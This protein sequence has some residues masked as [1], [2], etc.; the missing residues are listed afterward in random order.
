MLGQVPPAPANLYDSGRVSGN[1]NT[2][3]LDR[4]M[5]ARLRTVDIDISAVS[6]LRLLIMDVGSYSPERVRPAWVGAVLIGANGEMPLS[7]LRPKSGEALQTAVRLSG[8]VYPDALAPGLSELV[9]DIGGK[10]YTRL[11]AKIGLADECLQN[12]ISPAVRFFVFKDKPDLERLVQVEPGVPAPSPLRNPVT[13]DSVISTLF[14]AML[15]RPPSLQ[16]QRLASQAL[17]SRLTSE[18]LA[19]LLW[20]VAMQPEFQLIY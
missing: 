5:T 14:Q 9:Y 7:S 17:P 3:I 10:G 19:D 12:D 6:E 18:G 2:S 4:T 8:Q 15:G 1:T 11:Q 20:A 13:R 16:E